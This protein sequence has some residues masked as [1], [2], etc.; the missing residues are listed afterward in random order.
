MH[1]V[2]DKMIGVCWWNFGIKLHYF[3]IFFFPTI[4]KRA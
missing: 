1:T 3:K 4:D 2:K